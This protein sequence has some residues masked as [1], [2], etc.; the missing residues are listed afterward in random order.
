MHLADIGHSIVEVADARLSVLICSGTETFVLLVSMHRDVRH[1]MTG[2]PTVM[3]TVP[4]ASGR[5]A[6]RVGVRTVVTYGP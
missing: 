1:A 3:T 6:P 4:T 2:R 5:A